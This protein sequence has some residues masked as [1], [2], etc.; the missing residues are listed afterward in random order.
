[1]VLTVSLLAAALIAKFTKE[2]CCFSSLQNLTG[3]TSSTGFATQQCGMPM[4]ANKLLIDTAPLAP[5]VLSKMV[6]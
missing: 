1:M 2:E 6:A 4:N 3:F 5:F